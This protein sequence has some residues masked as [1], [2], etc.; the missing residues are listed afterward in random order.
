L[1]NVQ[2]QLKLDKVSSFAKDKK[3]KSLEELVLKIGYDPA[4]IKAVEE[5]I[6]K[7]NA[8]VAALRKQ[9]KISATE[10]P[11]DKEM[12]ETKGQKEEMLKLIMEQNTQIKEM[13]VELDKIVKEKEKNVPMEVIPLNAFHIT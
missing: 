6:K 7:K 9:L 4:N 3:I 12:V 11:Q 10:D 2:T 8:K 13:E 1:N 5:I